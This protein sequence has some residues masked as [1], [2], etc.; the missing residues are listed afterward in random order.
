[1]IK[2]IVRFLLSLVILLSSG[3]AQLDAYNRTKDS[4]YSS[5][6]D[7]KAQAK[8]IFGNL[9]NR[10]SVYKSTSSSFAEK[11]IRIDLEEKEI[12]EDEIVSRKYMEISQYFTSFFDPYTAGYFFHYLKRLP[13]C[14]HFSSLSS[15]WCL[16][17][18]FQ[19]FRI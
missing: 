16:T 1:M 12:E 9:R 3:Y 8:A 14:K 19:V 18:I 5:T 7:L 11:R 6:E 17:V 2:F 13:F 15:H 4:C 10:D